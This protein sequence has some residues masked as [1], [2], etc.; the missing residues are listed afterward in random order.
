M[1]R[2]LGFVAT[3]RSGPGSKPDRTVL[4]RNETKHNDAPGLKCSRGGRGGESSGDPLEPNL[5]GQAGNSREPQ[6]EPSRGRQ[7]QAKLPE[8][9]AQSGS[10]AREWKPAIRA[11]GIDPPR[12][13]YDF[14]R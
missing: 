13:I 14:R 1:E 6:L 10:E 7:K 3:S 11:A 4:R 8:T 9:K 5:G 2:E 12:R